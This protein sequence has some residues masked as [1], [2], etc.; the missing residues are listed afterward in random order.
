[1]KHPH[2]LGLVVF[3]VKAIENEIDKNKINDILNQT[4]NYME[5]II[6]NVEKGI[7]I[8]DKQGKITNINK[9]GVD[10]F[11]KEK[12]FL[13]KEDIYHIIFFY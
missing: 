3:G 11:Q 13:I 8:V 6:D 5:S 7:M 10:I 9:F 1:M 12:E 2:T 4:Y